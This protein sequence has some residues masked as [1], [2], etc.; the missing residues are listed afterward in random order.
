M[1]DL[2]KIATCCYCGTRAVLRLG[3]TAGHHTLTCRACGARLTD[4]KPL[5]KDRVQ[6]SAAEADRAAIPSRP[7]KYVKSKKK[8]PRR[9]VARLKDILE[10]VVDEIFD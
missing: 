1:P 9:W 7:A 5:R 4:M 2:T 10:D 3:G 8:K 6:A